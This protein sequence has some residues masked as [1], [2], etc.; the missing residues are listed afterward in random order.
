MHEH[1]DMSAEE[2]DDERAAER[3]VNEKL[4]ELFKIVENLE[5]RLIQLE[6][7]FR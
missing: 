6:K 3:E 7:S 2:L 4:D 5:S 1:A